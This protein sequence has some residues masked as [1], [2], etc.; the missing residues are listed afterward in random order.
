MLTKQIS[1]TQISRKFTL[2]SKFKEGDF[3]VDR[4]GAHGIIVFVKWSCCSD[5]SYR[6]RLKDGPI[7]TYKEHELRRGIETK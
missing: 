3:V 5:T 1:N 4:I 6:V 2:K 7:V